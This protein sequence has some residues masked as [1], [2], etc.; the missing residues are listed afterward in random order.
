MIELIH[1]DCLQAMKQ[2]NDNQFSIAIC[3]PPFG[4][5]N[6]VQNTGNKRGESVE[7]NN[8]IPSEEYFAEL[9]RVS[10]NRIVFG[11]NYYNCFEGKHG[12]I[13]WIKNQPMPNFSKAVIA[14][15]TFHQK[16]EVY[17]Q[18][19]TN[20]V[21]KGRSTKHPC[22]MPVD[23]FC[24]ILNNYAK[25]EDTILDTHAGS[26]SLAIACDKMG[27]D[28]VGFEKNEEYYLQAKERIKKHQS[29][30]KLFT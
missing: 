24:W 3:D 22:E 2:M 19:W 5:G 7:W 15:C 8:E 26:G 23:L 16:I 29:Q 25:E 14:S 11:A 30:L 10:K 6:F 17:T 27:F 21:A 1:G 4:I 13:V 9:R 28:Y 20:F 12:S 18:T